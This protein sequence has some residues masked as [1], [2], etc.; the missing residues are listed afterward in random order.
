M[1]TAKGL[2]GLKLAAS[3]GD[4]GSVSDLY[5]DDRS[6]TVRYLVVD[7]GTWLPGRRVLISPI[8]LR[9]S[10]DESA[11]EVSLTK[12]QVEAS[13]SVDSDKP[14]DRQY[15]EQF[16]QHYGYPYYWTGPYRWGASALP[17]DVAL[18]GVPIADLPVVEGG[19]PR[20]RSAADVMSYYIEAVDG[21]IGHVED[22]LVDGREWA[23]RY[24]VIDTRNW[25]PGKKVLVSPAWINEVSWP[26]SRVYVD[27]TREGVKSAPEYDPDHPLER[28]YESRL[29]QH[30]GRTRY[31]E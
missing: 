21:D 1:L 7:T 24:M 10:A 19:D 27:L 5:F 6:W 25:W 11:V 18:A 4:I 16:S 15:E 13:P 26:D 31:W 12:E 14:V 3:D 29:F 9:A 17:G 2:S 23:I 20:L 8:S 22:F 28:E 30:Y